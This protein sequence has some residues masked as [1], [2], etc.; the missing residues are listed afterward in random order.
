MAHHSE[1]QPPP[2]YMEQL[3]KDATR[4][5]DLGATGKYPLGKLTEQDEGELRL[6]I[7]HMEGKV[8][9]SFGKPVAWIGFTP[10]QAD[11]IATFLQEHA[12]AVRK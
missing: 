11:E 5:M 3:L 9:L 1:F 2:A 6:A 12:A 8:I 4:K 10:E 7:S